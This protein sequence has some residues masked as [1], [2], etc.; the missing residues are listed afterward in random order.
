MRTQNVRRMLFLVGFSCAMFS[1][2]MASD[3]DAVFDC[4]VKVAPEGLEP[5][6]PPPPSE[7]TCIGIIAKPCREAGGDNDQCNTRET[8]AWLAAI[9]SVQS[10]AEND[11]GKKQ[12]A[13]FKAGTSALLKNA[14]ALCRAAAATSAWGSDAIANG[15]DPTAF[16]RGH[17]CVR[18]S[19]GQQALIVLTRRMGI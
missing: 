7:Q 15:N 2:A 4:V 13:A 8:N 6:A 18:E 1:P 14:V 12:S 10:N 19:V 16:D 9:A 3:V 5:G 11:Y 17:P